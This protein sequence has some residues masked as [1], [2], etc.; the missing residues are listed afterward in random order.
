MNKR[1]GALVSVEDFS[2][3]DGNL[4]FSFFEACK[5][6]YNCKYYIHRSVYEFIACNIGKVKGS[7]KKKECAADAVTMRPVSSAGLESK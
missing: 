5:K 2:E 6:V 7:R 1:S 4:E 3:Q